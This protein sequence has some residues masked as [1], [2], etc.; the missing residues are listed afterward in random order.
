MISNF[1]FLKKRFSFFS[2]FHF[3]SLVTKIH[4]L[5]DSFRTT[6]NRIFSS[7]KDCTVELF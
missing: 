1:C 3:I 4:D 5:F 7:R 6:K 2:E